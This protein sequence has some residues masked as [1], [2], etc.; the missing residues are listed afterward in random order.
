MKTDDISDKALAEAR[1]YQLERLDTG[2]V[3]RAR[4]APPKQPLDKYLEK[5]RAIYPRLGLPCAT[6]L[7][8][9]LLAKSERR[10][11]WK[12]RGVDPLVDS[13]P[14]EIRPLPSP[15]SALDSYKKLERE[16]L[17][18]NKE[19]EREL[20]SDA[21]ET[22]LPPPD[23]YGALIRQPQFNML[24][25]AEEFALAKRWHEHGDIAA[26]DKLVNS[27]LRWVIS[28]AKQYH[29]QPRSDLIAAGNIGLMKAIELFDPENEKRARLATYAAPS[30]KGA[31][32]EYI[33]H[34]RSLVKMGTTD[35]QRKLFFNLREAKSEL[36]ALEDGDLRPDQ[37]K[38]IAERLDVTEQDVVEMN[39]RLGGDVSLN[40]LIRDDDGDD[41]EKDEPAFGLDAETQLLRAEASDNKR[42]LLNKALSVLNERERRIF[43]ARRLAEEPLTLEDLAAEFGVC[44]ARV[45]Q[46]EAK[47][48]TKLQRVMDDDK[49]YLRDSDT[50]QVWDNGGTR[51]PDRTWD[52]NEDTKFSR[53]DSQKVALHRLACDKSRPPSAAQKRK[54]EQ[55]R[56][57]AKRLRAEA[58]ALFRTRDASE[59]SRGNGKFGEVCPPGRTTIRKL[60]GKG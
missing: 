31:I 8:A 54:C 55:K 38:L 32:L 42:M 23:N 51:S 28:I 52:D 59:A 24:E 36:S 19:L 60:N 9:Q 56:E 10:K 39:R 14:A 48:L 34:S 27:H 53:Q 57:R 45:R 17:P 37:V 50:V 6:K 47:A 26:R 16:S 30:V 58:E 1:E 40:A 15:E 35:N 33:M 3:R 18:S 5:V 20:L 7:A 43:E 22:S 44:A 2:S 13:H 11:A 46:I 49:A 21:A 12:K 4:R 29:G 41:G 25:A